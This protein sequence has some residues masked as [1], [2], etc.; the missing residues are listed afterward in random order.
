MQ[1]SF[2]ELEYATK[3]KHTYLGEIHNNTNLPQSNQSTFLTTDFILNKLDI[4]L[5][6]GYATGQT[7]DRLILK[8]IIGMPF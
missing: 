4:D 8:T 7:P 3:K 1:A 2:S 5:G 6:I